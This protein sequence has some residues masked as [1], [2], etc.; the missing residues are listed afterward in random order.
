MNIFAKFQLSSANSFLGSLFFNVFRK[1]SLS[2]AIVI[3]QIQR[4]GQK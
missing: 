3:N 1:F 2:V 4:F